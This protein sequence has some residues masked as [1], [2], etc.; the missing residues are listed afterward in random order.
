[1]SNR[2]KGLFSI[3]LLILITIDIASAQFVEMDEG[4]TVSLKRLIE[5]AAKEQEQILSY[6]FDHENLS[7]LK[8]VFRD[9]INDNALACYDR[10]THA[11]YF[12]S[13]FILGVGLDLLNSLLADDTDLVSQNIACD[14]VRTIHHELGHIWCIQYAKACLGK[15][16]KKCWLIKD[17]NIAV[18]L[19]HEGL[20]NCIESLVYK[21]KT[22]PEFDWS[23]FTVEEMYADN[24]IFHCV[25]YQAGHN[26]VGTIY[27]RYGDMPST[28]LYISRHRLKITDDFDTV[29]KYL[30]E[31]NQFADDRLLMKFNSSR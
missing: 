18:R 8:I 19:M 15:K 4:Y 9:Y 29:A 14:L 2:A 20:A 7:K 28:L 22:T 17:K 12:K 26:L 3:I 31:A 21:N 27:K 23:W 11:L 13:A 16:F 1:V 30:E 6:R 10:K 25:I 24:E 5:R